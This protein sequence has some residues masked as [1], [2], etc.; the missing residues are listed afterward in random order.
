MPIISALD[1]PEVIVG[2]VFIMF[3][4]VLIA[5]IGEELWEKFG[6]D[7]P[8]WTGEKHEAY[9][10]AGCPDLDEWEAIWPFEQEF[11]SPLKEWEIFRDYVKEFE[12]GESAL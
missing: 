7:P 12:D 8:H 2:F 3:A 5:F 9:E 6:G 1:H 10:R 11:M 4:V